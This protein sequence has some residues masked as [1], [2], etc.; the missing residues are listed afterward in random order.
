MKRYFKYVKPYLAAFI[1][2]PLM[3]IVEVIGEVLLPSMMADI[4]NI[5][6]ADH[7]IS[8]IVSK[9][10]MMILTAF[11]MMA[12]GIGGAYFAARAAKMHGRPDRKS[13][14]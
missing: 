3:M 13:V 12:G 6:A 2:G 8:Y 4:I 14:V 10:V 1:L 7:N 9:G 11:I 5:G